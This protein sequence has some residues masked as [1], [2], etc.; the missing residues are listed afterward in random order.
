MGGTDGLVKMDT[1]SKS[2]PFARL[3]VVRDGGLETEIGR[4]E[5]IQDTQRPKWAQG[6]KLDYHFEES[7]TVKQKQIA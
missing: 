2:D 4:T 1:F 5:V 7:Q 3:V 6:I